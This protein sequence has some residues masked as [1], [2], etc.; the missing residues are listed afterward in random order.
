MFD[1]R[2]ARINHRTRSRERR[3]IIKLFF[4][5]FVCFPRDIIDAAAIVYTRV[6]TGGVP[7]TRAVTRQKK[8]HSKDGAVRKGRAVVLPPGH[9]VG[10]LFRER[11]SRLYRLITGT[12]V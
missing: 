8:S 4:F 3:S 6:C 1:R 2:R 7:E 5:F 10:F 12:D 9:G 11:K